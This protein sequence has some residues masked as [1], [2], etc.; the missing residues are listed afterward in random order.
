MFRKAR[1]FEEWVEDVTKRHNG[2]YTY[3]GMFSKTGKPWLFAACPEHGEFVV[4]ASAHL[5]IGQGCKPCGIASRAAKNRLTFEDFTTRAAAKHGNKYTYKS[6]GVSKS[7]ASTV[8][9]VCPRHGEFEQ[10]TDVHLSGSGCKKCANEAAGARSRFSEDQWLARFKEVWGDTYTYGKFS[11]R[12]R[13][14]KSDGKVEVEVIC[15]EH[16]VEIK[17]AERHSAGDGCSKCGDKT[18]ANFIQSSDS[19]I[20]AA[21]KEAHGEKYTYGRIYFDGELGSPKR[22][23]VM[24]ITCP[25]HGTF[26]QGVKFHIKGQGCRACGITSRVDA[27]RYT[28]EDVVARA[29]EVHG[30]FFKH[31]ELTPTGATGLARIVVICPTHGEFSQIV[32]AHLAGSGCPRCYTKISKPNLEMQAYLESLGVTVELEHKLVVGRKYYADL[33][34]PE[35]KLAIEHLGLFWHSSKYKS[36][37]ELLERQ[38]AFESAGYKFIA[39]YE[40]EWRDKRAIVENTLKA[41]LGLVSEKVYARKCKVMR[42]NTTETRKFLMENHIQGFAV[43]DSFGLLHNEKLVACAVFSNNLSDR[44][45]AASDTAYELVRYASAC[46]VVGGLSKLLAAFKLEF[47]SVRSITSFSDKRLHAGATYAKLG[48][49]ELYTLRPDYTYLVKRNRRHKSGFQKSK[50]LKSFPEVVP[51]TEKEMT[52]SL[53]IYRVYDTG[54]VKWELCL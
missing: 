50:I 13:G 4:N 34:I 40:D 15:A 52:E 22:K 42:L 2:K 45:K 9:A 7:G 25:T 1:T 18:T 33:Y 49:R 21:A 53:G 17:A 30:E 28:L 37:G 32:S 3:T 23:R 41:K 12:N 11:T 31:G 26:I 5:G 27:A 19:E 35:A 24:E 20:L 29:K 10:L 54:K 39:I 43:G 51:G 38:K 6:L 44:W 8:H 36:S 47:P 14:I 48:F 16:G 46:S